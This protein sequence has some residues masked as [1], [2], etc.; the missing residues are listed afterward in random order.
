MGMYLDFLLTCEMN[1]FDSKTTVQG[2][3]CNK[4]QAPWD[5]DNAEVDDPCRAQVLVDHKGRWWHMACAGAELAL[6]P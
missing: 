6:L 4:P 1:K 5:D 2:C 3:H